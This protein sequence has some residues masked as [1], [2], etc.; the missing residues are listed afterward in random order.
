MTEEILL[1][2]LHREPGGPVDNTAFYRAQVDSFRIVALGLRQTTWY[3]G[4]GRVDCNGDYP[5]PDA[6]LLASVAVDSLH[7]TS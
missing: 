5:W 4:S 3:F 2:C 7:S 1:E 6:L